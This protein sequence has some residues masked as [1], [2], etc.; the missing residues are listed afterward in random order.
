M[1]RIYDKEFESYLFPGDATHGQSMIHIDDLVSC[2]R[3]VIEKRHDLA[4]LE[5]F[6]VGEP[7]VMSYEELQDQIGEL[8]H[9]EEWPAIR[10]PKAVAKAG[11]YAMKA[12]TDED[13]IKPWMIDLADQDYRIDISK[14]RRLLGW[15]P[16]R[17]LRD[18]L[19]KIAAR[20]LE[21]PDEWF[22]RNGILE[23]AEVK[24]DR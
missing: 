13:F 12:F 1:K 2:I 9:G 11:A 21:N 6:L 14:A 23:P 19:P 18:T 7:D 15:E 22:Q 10:I 8:L 3:R 16:R 24:E 20:L 5:R 17:R 4:G